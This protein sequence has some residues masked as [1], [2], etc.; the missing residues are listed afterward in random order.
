MTS[1]CDKH[2]FCYDTCN[3]KRKDCDDKFKKCVTKACKK[4]KD[5]GLFTNEEYEG[6]KLLKHSVF[7]M[8]V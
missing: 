5:K 4:H 1:C 7:E 3:N 6:N 8:H 2:D